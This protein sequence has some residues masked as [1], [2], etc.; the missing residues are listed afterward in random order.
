MNFPKITIS[1]PV[2]QVS[3][4]YSQRILDDGHKLLLTQPPFYAEHGPFIRKWENGAHSLCLPLSPVLKSDLTKIQNF[5]SDR[6]VIPEDVI[7]YP[8]KKLKPTFVGDDLF[9]TMSK[10]CSLF[11]FVNGRNAYECITENDFGKGEYYVTIEVSHVYI[12]PHQN[13]EN[14][15]LSLRV[16]NIIYKPAAEENGFS[17]LMSLFDTDPTSEQTSAVEKPKRSRKKKTCVGGVPAA[18]NQ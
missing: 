3:G 10:W 6:I 12:G 15:S 2:Q 16:R 7:D 18:L 14:C 11:K 17:E 1:D 5:I 8:N 9:I 13:G 4:R